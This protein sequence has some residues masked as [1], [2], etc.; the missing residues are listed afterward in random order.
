MLFII[1]GPWYLRQ[2]KRPALLVCSL[3]VSVNSSQLCFNCVWFFKNVLLEYYTSKPW[4]PGN[5]GTGM[6]SPGSINF[7]LQ[8]WVLPAT[9]AI[10]IFLL[11]LKMFITKIISHLLCDKQTC[12]CDLTSIE[13]VQLKFL[14]VLHC[15]F[16]TPYQIPSWDWSLVKVP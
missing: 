2:F 12:L 8:F 6:S 5:N 11:Q 14:R 16:L 3:W 9:I 15:E 4:Q 7:Q 1:F 10:T 13:G